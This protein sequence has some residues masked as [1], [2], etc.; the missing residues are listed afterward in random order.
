MVVAGDCYFDV[1]LSARLYPVRVIGSAPN[2]MY[3]MTM[4]N[5]KPAYPVSV[6][7]VE[8]ARGRIDNEVFGPEFRELSA[9]II[10]RL[11]CASL[12]LH[13]SLKCKSLVVAPQAN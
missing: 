11:G 8:P 12:D 3:V 5:R 10:T 2:A 13:L 4:M 7:P 6:P 1:F 9:S